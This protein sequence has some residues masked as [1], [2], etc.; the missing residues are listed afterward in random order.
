MK[1][2]SVSIKIAVRTMNTTP[3]P[4]P[5]FSEGANSRGGEAIFKKRSETVDMAALT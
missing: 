3:T 4:T 2:V 1:L 5:R